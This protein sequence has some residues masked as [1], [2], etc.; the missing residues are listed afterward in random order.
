MF[1]TH[2]VFSG[3]NGGPTSG[4][5]VSQL[6]RRLLEHD[7]EHGGRGLQVDHRQ[8]VVVPD[9]HAGRRVLA[10]RAEHLRRHT[11]HPTVVGGRH[12]RRYLRFRNRVHLLLRGKA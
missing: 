9:G 7:P 4:G 10:V 3:R 8:R 5:H 2:C 12:G 1:V 11:V 6:D